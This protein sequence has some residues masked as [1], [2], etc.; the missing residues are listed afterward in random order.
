MKKII[1]IL[2][3]NTMI[4]FNAK[5]QSFDLVPKA[6]FTLN[7]AL[8]TNDIFYDF[9][10][11]ANFVNK[12]TNETFVWEKDII[13]A[14]EEWISTVC[15]PKA[16]YGPEYT[17]ATFPIPA[18]STST[19]GLYVGFITQGKLGTAKLDLKIYPAD[20]PELAKKYSFVVN[21][22]QTLSVNSK[23]TVTT[24][25]MYPNP[26]VENI[27]ISATNLSNYQG[28]ADITNVEGKIVKSVNLNG[29]S[30]LSINVYDLANGIYKLQFTSEK[31]THVS[32]SFL[33]K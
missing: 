29:N 18:N 19:N 16:C 23:K 31:G 2:F 11:E 7:A 6:G 28:T 20:K 27:N 24:F 10:V 8:D 9:K 17:K 4:L 21:V 14:P 15:D 32:Q 3:I 5:A 1:T 26:C 12:S 22:S 33:K 30:D 13:S 25:A